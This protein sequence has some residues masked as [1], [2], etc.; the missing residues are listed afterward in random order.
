MKLSTPSIARALRHA[1]ALTLAVCIAACGGSD[2]AAPEPEPEPPAPVATGE[3]QVFAAGPSF[4]P[5]ADVQVQAVG[6]AANAVTAADGRG[7]LV[8]PAAKPALVKFSK[9][10]YADTFRV[11]GFDAGSTAT[12]ASVRLRERDPSQS[13]DATVGGTLNARDGTRLVLAAGSLV[14]AQTGAAIS[15][16]VDVAMT[17]VDVS[18]D[19]LSAFPGRFRGITASGSQPL[20]ASYGTT[21][22]MLT[23][24]G[25]RL[26]LAAGQTAEILLPIYTPQHDATTPVAVGD[27][28]PLWSLDE[29][30][31]MWKQEGSGTV[32]AAPDSPTGLAMRAVVGHFSWWNCDI[33]IPSGHLDVD[34]EMPDVPDEDREPPPP[35][36]WEPNADPN[37]YKIGPTRL[38]HIDGRTADDR[39]LRQAGIDFDAV[40]KGEGNRADRRFAQGEV[41][42][43]P[44][45]MM[46]PA[47]R[48]LSITA[49]TRVKRGGSGYPL[50]YA[51]GTGTVSVAPNASAKLTIRL[52]IDSPLNV[53]YVVT[54]PRPASVEPGQTATFDVAATRV[55]GGTERLVYQWTRNGQDIA[56]AAAASYTT[57]ALALADD[58][59]VYGVRVSTPV[60]FT[61][62][63][64]ARLRVTA[65]PPP[66]PP[67]ATGDR[68]ANPA[69]GNDANPGSAA[70]PWRSLSHAM[71][72]TPAGATLWLQ[73]GT[74]TAAADAELAAGKNGPNCFNHRAV[75]ADLRIRAVSQGAAIV[76]HD[77]YY[78]MCLMRSELHG[79][80]IVGPLASNDPSVST[81][82]IRIEGPGA[83]L[84]RG[85]FLERSRIV[86]LRAAKVTIEANGLASYGHVGGHSTPTLVAQNAGTEVT[87]DGGAFLDVPRHANARLATGACRKAAITA[88]DGAKVVLRGVTLRAGG[89]EVPSDGSYAVGAD[90]CTGGTLELRDSSW[91]E[92]FTIGA[93]LSGGTFRLDA[94][95]LSL[96]DTGLSIETFGGEATLANGA[97][98]DGSGEDGIAI[99]GGTGTR[100]ARLAVTS[101]ATIRNSGR[102]GILFSNREPE[103][104]IDGGSVIDNRSTGLRVLGLTCRIRNAR[105]TGNLAGGVRVENRSSTVTQ[106]SCDLGTAASPGGNTLD[107]PVYNLLVETREVVHPAVGNIW[108]ASEQGADAQGRYSVPAGQT[109]L[110]IAGPNLTGRN[111]RVTL[112]SSSVLVAQ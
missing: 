17:P 52:V 13:I 54:H 47:N 82:G 34:V 37:L 2:P 45:G 57:A 81:G 101:G 27:V 48:L 74:W 111:V 49:C 14:D 31:G 71:A 16:A 22:F 26:N 91:L 67:P 23:Q 35:V 29:A 90:A 21:E 20:I 68:H 44:S 103:L 53:P 51:C 46:V 63:L 24:N 87:V 64:P 42:A 104:L 58:D 3:V 72:N 55:A 39:L 93:R 41:V 62:S 77:S 30:S 9:T 107:N 78:P 88:S 96:N 61:T 33:E 76:Q 95:M 105:I 1:A 89:P 25:R 69:S 97:I 4:A 108:T 11:V 12:M 99:G 40:F 56:G 98:I 66:P 94:S 59:A 32:V 60:G 86:A 85:V 7:T 75:K 112:G 5:L 19:E 100:Q 65:P 106:D 80:H 38:F 110:V 18:G 79:V 92:G 6:L 109:S 73:D 83:T 70:A 84:L 36:P 8:L 15:G 50:V 10:G 43:G 28:I 102:H